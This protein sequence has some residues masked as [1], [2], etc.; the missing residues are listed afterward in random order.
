MRIDI[1]GHHHETHH[2]S[3]TGKQIKDLGHHE[4]GTLL[5]VEGEN[6]HRVADDETV[7]LRDGEQF[8]IE[9]HENEHHDITIEVDGQ[10][11][12]ANRHQMTGAEIKQLARRPPGNTLY[13]LEGRERIRVDDGQTVHLQERERFITLPPVGQ[14]A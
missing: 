5:R 13:R 3:L 11:F 4:H 14:A 7:H 2:H 8:V 9:M 1:N 12:H 10:A 6:R